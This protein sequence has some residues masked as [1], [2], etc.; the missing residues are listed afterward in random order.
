METQLPRLHWPRLS[1]PNANMAEY[2]NEH[3]VGRLGAHF[4]NFGMTAGSELISIN[5]RDIR[6]VTV[7]GCRKHVS[8]LL[9]VS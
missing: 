6:E 1:G 8:K 9:W 2:G 3:T 5:L 7:L 4:R